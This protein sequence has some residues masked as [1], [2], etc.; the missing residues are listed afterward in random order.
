[1]DDIHKESNFDE[2]E[3]K[4]FISRM[5]IT[6][7]YMGIPLILSF[8]V[9]DI[10]FHPEL[11]W[12]FLKVRL[13]CIPVAFFSY[14]L[15]RF[16]L[17]R[18]KY[19]SVPAIVGSVYLGVYT[20]YM[21][22]LSG[23]EHSSYYA[24]LNLIAIGLLSFL[25]WKLWSM[26]LCVIANYGPYLLVVLVKKGM[27]LDS[28]AF[29]PHLAFCASTIFMGWLTNHLSRG[30]RQREYESRMSLIHELKTKDIVIK[31][32]T[33]E[34]IYLEK[35]AN[36]FSPQVIE[37]VKNGRLSVEGMLRREITCLFIDV[38]NSTSRSVRLDRDDYTKILS[39]FF[40]LASELLTKFEMTVGSFLGDGLVGF[41][42]APLE[43]QDHRYKAVAAGI[44]ILRAHKEKQDYFSER[45]RSSFDIRI[46]VNTGFAFVGFFPSFKRGTYTALGAPV[47]LAARLCTN[48][49]ANSILLT[50][51]LTREIGAR[52]KDVI[53]S[54]MGMS[55]SMKGFEG[56]TFE[57]FSIVPAFEQSSRETSNCPL[58]GG[59]LFIQNDLAD[60]VL[61]KCG[62][63][64]YTDLMPKETQIRGKAA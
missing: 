49:S 8:S 27:S 62:T 30:L 48:A 41:A 35:L 13:L 9:V 19:Y 24:G 29:V 64:G 18:D 34:G 47:N 26:A 22:S 5:R 42:N 16:G 61:K 56:E 55:D 7:Y 45:W 21:V 54:P 43:N 3:R 10:F 63:C 53:V 36:Q 6:A 4:L 44:A 32:K 39:E 52:L 28:S 14:N 59:Q 57:L 17:F 12:V 11:F 25:P 1:M 37:S 2:E 33:K 50:K 46:G 23:Y 38:V 20:A 40:T 51:S 15:Y 31:E 58:C 60:S